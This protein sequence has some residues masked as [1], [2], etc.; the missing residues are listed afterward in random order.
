[1]NSIVYHIVKSF[2][3]QLST[4]GGVVES[5]AEFVGRPASATVLGQKPADSDS[6]N[7][8]NCGRAFPDELREDSNPDGFPHF[9]WTV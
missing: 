4:G 9:A 2:Q 7:W 8:G 5:G 3:K 1:M 6:A